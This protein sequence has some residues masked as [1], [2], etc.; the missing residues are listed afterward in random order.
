MLDKLTMVLIASPKEDRYSNKAVVSLIE[1]SVPVLP[2]GR[3]P[4]QISGVAIETERI[5]FNDIHTI[6]LYLN[7]F[8]QVPFYDYI[9][10]LKPKRVI[11]NPGT[12]NK[13]LQDLLDSHSIYWEEACTLVMLATKQY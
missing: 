8:N 6:S 9:A 10:S 3:R 12:E 7:P 1:N 2:F 4:G 11:F 13:E 5:H